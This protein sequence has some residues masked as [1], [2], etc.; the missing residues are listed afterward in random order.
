MQRFSRQKINKATE[1]L[2]DTKEWSELVIFRTLPQK[3]K[4]PIRIYILF[5]CTWNISLG[6]TAYWATKVTNLNQFK[7]IEIILSIFSDNNGM[8]T[9][10]QLQEKENVKKTD[11]METKQHSTAK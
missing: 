6:L 5:R 9:R 1:M 2:N 8:K 3:K 11:Y 4:K 10:S 7:S